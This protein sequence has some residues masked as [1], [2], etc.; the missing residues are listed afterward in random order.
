MNE[1]QNR[2]LEAF[3]PVMFIDALRVNI[4]DEGHVS[5]KSVYLA[6]AMGI[7]N[8]FKNRSF[9]DILIAMVDGLTGF[10]E[11]INSIFPKT[12][13]QLCIRTLVRVYMVRSSMK[14]IPNKDRKALTVD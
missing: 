7:L 2:P 3:Y 6:L 5:K 14:Y 10:P 8:E 13:V 1:W 9:K 4:S 11:A 12:E